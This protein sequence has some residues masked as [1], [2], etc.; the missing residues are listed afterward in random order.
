MRIGAWRGY[1]VAGAAATGVYYLLP[2]PGQ[3]VLNVL[4]GC[5]AVAAIAAGIRSFRPAGAAAWWLLAGGQAAFVVGD[6]LFSVFELVL[7]VD[8]FPSVADGV[9][10]VGYPFMAAG[11]VLLIRGR[12][13][14][15]DWAAALDGAIIAVG[16]GLL[17]WVLVMVP[18][19][20]D[21]SLTVPERVFSLAYPAADVLLLALA[22]RFMVAPGRH[23]AAYPL[24]AASLVLTLAADTVFGVLALSEQY[25]GTSLADAGFMLAYLALG[26]S[27]LHPSMGRLSEPAPEKQARLG[28]GRLLVM[29]AASLV[30]PAM[31]LVKGLLGGGEVDV[32]ATAGG[33]GVLF[34]LASVR[35]VGLVRELERTE[36]D[37]RRLLDRT[38]QVAEQERSKV[39]AEL[40][41]GPIQRL[42]ALAYE[43]ERARR[44]LLGAKAAEG[45]AR[46]E[47]AQAG[48]S[49]EVQGLRELMVS[50]RPPVLDEMGLEAALRDQVE[51]F[52]RRSGVACTFRVALAGRLDGDLETVVYRVAQEALLNV[53]RHAR[54]SKLW[55]TLQADGDR[56]GLEIRDDGVGFAPP[57]GSVLVR[58]GHFG[59]A[60]MRERVEMAGGTWAVE[61]QPGAG[62]TIR[63]AFAAPRAA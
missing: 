53:A 56:V 35:V 18:Y 45:M 23:T 44:R 60:G 50:L 19:F 3:A 62:A 26:A 28:R 5:S 40:H 43:L 24:L 17:T 1:L 46:L 10:L 14:R 33:W 27:A 16:F 22:A 6:V 58:E 21:P 63:A 13:P 30:A 37:R 25:D 8:P 12:S 42:V 9:Y 55:L 7:K 11:L 38:F 36:A 2:R 52:A 31:L 59:L 29:A 47:R 4:V 20:R 51:G 32:A 57:P 61:S 48:L 54:A 49:S 15:R 34:V 41:D 39:A